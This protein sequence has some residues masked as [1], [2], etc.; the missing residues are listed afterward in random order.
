MHVRSVILMALIS[1]AVPSV[2][3]ASQPTQPGEA[4]FGLNLIPSGQPR[5]G[6]VFPLRV[7]AGSAVGTKCIGEVRIQVPREVEVVS[8]DT[9]R[10]AHVSPRWMGPQ[11][12]E[13]TL[14][15][16]PSQVGRFTIRGTLRV[17]CGE[18]NSW[19]QETETLVDLD[20]RSDTTLVHGGYPTRYEQVVG[21]IRFRYGGARLERDSVS[22][23]LVL[24][25][26][27]MV[28]IDSS[29]ALLKDDITDR[30]QLMDSPHAVCGDCVLSEPV[31]VR[32]AVTVGA[33]GSVTWIEPPS[34]GE[35]PEDPRIVAAA[36]EAL[37]RFHFRPARGRGRAVADWAEV[38]VI[39]EP[40]PR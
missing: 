20:V 5:L 9:F 28:R 3:G 7:M 40:P 1:V 19:R 10:T 15:L 6:E 17:S 18:P 27:H 12:A 29:E 32:R 26:G 37:K 33:D 24:R 39:V 23:Q 35:L 2:G 16:R 4:Y 14:R 13:W 21:G 34:A 31:R 11:D 8:G 25:P 30:P 22:H 38:N 36:E